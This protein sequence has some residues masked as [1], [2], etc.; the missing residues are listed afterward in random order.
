MSDNVEVTNYVTPDIEIERAFS[1]LENTPGL[2]DFKIRGFSLYAITRFDLE[3][4]YRSDVHSTDKPVKSDQNG[5]SQKNQRT[6]NSMSFGTRFRNKIREFRKWFDRRKY[7]S[8]FNDIKEA[9]P[10]T[11]LLF[12]ATS[13]FRNAQGYSVEMEDVIK[14]RWQHGNK[15]FFVLPDYDI[16]IRR[17]N[18]YDYFYPM[19]LE[20]T[21][22]ARK[23][24][25]KIIEAYISFLEKN[26]PGIGRLEG[27]RKTIYFNFGMAD[28]LKE[29]ILHV[30]PKFVIGRSL[31]SEKWVNIACR[32][33]NTGSIEIQHGA[34]TRHNFY[35]YPLGILDVKELLFPDVV[36]CLG[37]EWLRLLREQSETWNEKN[38]AVIG[39]PQGMSRKRPPRNGKKRVLVAFQNFSIS[40]LDFRKDISEL[41]SVYHGSI[42]NCEFVFRV[43]PSDFSNLQWDLAAGSQI[44]FSDPRKM[45]PRNALENTDIL[46]CATTMM[47][48]E[49]LSMGIPVV[50]FERFRYMTEPNGIRF[51][52][53]TAELFSA[54][55]CDIDESKER[56]EYISSSDFSFLDTLV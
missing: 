51:V 25:D 28:Q 44:S 1:K 5:V 29:I 2:S 40:N 47:I 38:S 46:V 13:G 37:K 9:L 36:L 4:Q 52:S 55:T 34:F 10:D 14:H 11:N 18:E 20:K 49:A 50:S 22:E 39:S 35:Y 30:K 12:V 15:I 19:S 31:Y 48:Y 17:R 42:Q 23:D 32:E 21:H 41:F 45:S 3:V 33:T 16:K 26:L 6:E 56:L 27:I 24:Y 7:L 53:N 8:Q 43:H 54:I